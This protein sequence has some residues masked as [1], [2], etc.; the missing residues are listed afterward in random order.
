VLLN[1]CFTRS[2]LF[3]LAVILCVCVTITNDCAFHRQINSS[4]KKEEAALQKLDPKQIGFHE[5]IKHQ[6]KMAAKATKKKQEIEA[7]AGRNEQAVI[8]LEQQLSEIKKTATKVCQ[9][10][11]DTLFR[12]PCHLL[13]QK[14]ELT[15]SFALATPPLLWIQFEKK[16][17]QG[18]SNVV[19]NEAQFKEYH[20]LKETANSRTARSGAA[21]AKKKVCRLRFPPFPITSIF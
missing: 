14:A 9:S 2:R 17:A 12:F 20:S 7:Q 8:D 19:L 15:G 4:I 10:I 5:K 6:K 3:L 11:V 16:H 21:L 18:S 13:L 1:L